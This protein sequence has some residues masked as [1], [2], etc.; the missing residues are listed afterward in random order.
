VNRLFLDANVLFTAA[1][2]PDGKASLII[3]IG[4]KG[5]WEVYTSGF[6]VEEA[7]RN[8][9][10]KYPSVEK[11]F[12]ELISSITI[13][14]ETP[15]SPYPPY[16]DEKDRPIFR[17]AYACRASHLITGDIAHFGVFMSKPEETAGIII[18]TPAMFLSSL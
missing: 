16:L 10:V 1:H 7:R 15:D 17:S 4:I 5:A 14:S 11:K 13:V 18:L 9:A 3:S 8:L 2:N 12:N 6:A